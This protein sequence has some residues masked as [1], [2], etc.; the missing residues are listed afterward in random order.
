MKAD[1]H[2]A[3]VAAMAYSDLDNKVARIIKELGYPG[4][5]FINVD[6]AQAYILWNTEHVTIAFRGTEPKQ[7]SD[8]VADLKAWKS[9]SKVAGRVHDGFYDEIAKLWPQITEE[10]QNHKKR[11]ISVCGHSLGGAMATICAARLA[12]DGKEVMLY[13][14][15]SP[16]VGNKKFVNS[17]KCNHRRWV[18]NNDAVPKVPPAL[19]GFR[20][21]GELCYL[22]YYGNVRNGLSVWQRFKDQLRGRWRAICKFEF[23]DGVRDHS[24]DQYVSKLEKHADCQD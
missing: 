10:M 4:Y 16:R 6:G 1:F 11:S 20:H 21:H 9:K 23:F 22:N 3:T 14:F 19:L 15:G 8:I 12:D 17:I 2:H 13:T 24:M 7:L 18:N 5:K